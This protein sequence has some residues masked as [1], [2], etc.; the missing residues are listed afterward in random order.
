MNNIENKI[1][2]MRF[3]NAQFEAAIAQT[4]NTLDKF[5]EKLNFKGA[6]KG[7]DNL[8]KTT[9][10]YNY[11]LNDIGSSLDMLTNRFSTM[12]TIGG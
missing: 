6:E 1:V 11:T 12:G 7:L 3:D 10:N 8:G 2:Q 9:G 4:M 5:K